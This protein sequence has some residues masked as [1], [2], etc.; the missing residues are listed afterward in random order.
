M[1]HSSACI[2]QESMVLCLFE[3][4]ET[5]RHTE[6]LFGAPV[7]VQLV[8]VTLYREVT[9]ERSAST[10]NTY[11]GKPVETTKTAMYEMKVSFFNIKNGNSTSRMQ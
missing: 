5:S 8:K 10:T 6:E 9:G 3:A 4:R 11:L 1:K 7:S 2:V